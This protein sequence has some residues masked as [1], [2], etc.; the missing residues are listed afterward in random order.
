METEE[1]S[2]TMVFTS[3]LTGLIAREDFSTFICHEIQIL[4]SYVSY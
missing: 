3:T 2:E 4:T 1:I